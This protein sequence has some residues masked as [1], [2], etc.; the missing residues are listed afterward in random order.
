M[1][2]TPMSAVPVVTS[3]L[4]GIDFLIDWLIALE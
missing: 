1:D 3:Q 4:V 2:D